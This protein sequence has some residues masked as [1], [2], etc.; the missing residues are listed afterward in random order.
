[1]AA[2]A[3]AATTANP[4]SGLQPPQQQQQQAPQTGDGGNTP[5]PGG[6]A[7]R[8]RAN[9]GSSRA[10]NALAVMTFRREVDLRAGRS[11]QERVFFCLLSCFTTFSDDFL[12][13]GP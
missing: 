3:P 1:M 9:P 12:Q 13:T 10:A 2:P 4:A 5:F 7:D 11:I 6:L 8:L